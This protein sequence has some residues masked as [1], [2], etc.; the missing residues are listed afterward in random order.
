MK[1]TRRWERRLTRYSIHPAT[2]LSAACHPS[3]RER[4]RAKKQFSDV[5][6]S[7]SEG[8]LRWHANCL[9]A[10]LITYVLLFAL[11]E[12]LICASCFVRICTV[13]IFGRSRVL[14]KWNLVWFCRWKP[15]VEGERPKKEGEAGRIRITA[16]NGQIKKKKQKQIKQTNKETNDH[17]FITRQP[18]CVAQTHTHKHARTHREFTM[19]NIFW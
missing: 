13:G 17:A 10:L 5:N 18:H 3:V 1:L 7:V 2:S 11:K 12:E 9:K 8:M 19:V 6:G 15:H 14:V 4:E 16:P